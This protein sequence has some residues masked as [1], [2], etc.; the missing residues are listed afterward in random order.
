[1]LC[2][3]VHDIPLPVYGG[4]QVQEKSLLTPI[5]RQS[6]LESHGLEEHGSG[7][8]DAHTSLIYMISE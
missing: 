3:L 1:M 6:A 5:C 8:I 4:L 7:A 2:I